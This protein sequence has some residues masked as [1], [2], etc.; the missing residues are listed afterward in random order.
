[1][2]NT[3][4]DFGTS[5]TSK[6]SSQAA[7][8]EHLTDIR[9]GH[10]R[11]KLTSS[12]S[13]GVANLTPEQ[14]AKKR[15]NDREAQRAIRER[16]KIQIETLEQKIKDLT[17]QQPYQDLQGLI[18]QKDILQTENEEIR[19]QLASVIQTL[20]AC[21]SNTGK[22]MLCSSSLLQTIL[23]M[24]VADCQRIALLMIL[25]SAPEALERPS[26]HIPITLVT[27]Q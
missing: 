26:T 23:T 22:G 6:S 1:M 8:S 27:H 2:E 13:R 5:P 14:L 21:V 9:H 7:D 25:Q 20:Q 15:A 18:R 3:L 24:S 11:Q 12:S 16:T 17:S 19:R 10:K 4:R